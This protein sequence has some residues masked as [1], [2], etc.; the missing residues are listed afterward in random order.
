MTPWICCP[1]PR[2]SLPWIWHQDICRSR[3]IPSWRKRQCLQH[4]LDSTNLWWWPLG[5]APA[6]FQRLM[7]TVLTDLAWDSRMVYVDDILVIEATS[8]EPSVSFCSTACCWLVPGVTEM[9][10][11]KREVTYLGYV[12]SSD[13]ISPD[14]AKFDAVI[15]FSQPSDLRTLQSFLDLGS[16]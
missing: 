11:C 15:D 7:E 12:V 6:T 8:W 5:C 3:C 16:Y 9:L 2:F 1:E 14:I 4:S 13:G 10:L